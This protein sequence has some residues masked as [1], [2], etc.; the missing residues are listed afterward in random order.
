[1]QLV[2]LFCF[3]VFLIFCSEFSKTRNQERNKEILTAKQKIKNRK[4]I[5]DA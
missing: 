5:N 4:L 1:M 3:H 2:N